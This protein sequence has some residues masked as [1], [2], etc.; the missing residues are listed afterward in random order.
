RLGI[1]INW[2]FQRNSPLMLSAAVGTTQRKE[3]S[4]NQTGHAEFAIDPLPEERPTSELC[5]KRSPR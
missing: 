2:T 5:N 3:D 1:M 4:F